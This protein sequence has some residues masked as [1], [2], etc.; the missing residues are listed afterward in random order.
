MAKI[1]AI[2]NQSAELTIDP[3]A[4]GDSFI[5]FDI[6][7]TGEFRVG[8]DDYRYSSYARFGY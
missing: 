8:V 1:N 3:G 7:T 5:Q 6:N 4:S 2:N